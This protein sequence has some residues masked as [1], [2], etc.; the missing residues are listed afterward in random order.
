MNKKMVNYHSHKYYTNAMTIADS[1][2]SYE[3]YIDRE[4]IKKIK[5]RV[6]KEPKKERFCKYCGKPLEGKKYKYTYCSVEC[7]RDSN[8]GTRPSFLDLI[9]DFKELKSF[10]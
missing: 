10:V 9:N 6:I 8:K 7:Y 5:R 3:E 1:P 4:K 2:A